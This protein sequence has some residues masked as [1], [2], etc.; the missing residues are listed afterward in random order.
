VLLRARVG[1]CLVRKRARD[2]E[3]E[4]LRQVRLLTAAAESLEA[5]RLDATALAEVTARR[6]ALG[7]LARVLERAA[8]EIHAREQRLALQVQ[9]LRI[10]IDETRKA[11]A[12]AEIVE[13]DYFHELQRRAAELRRQV[14]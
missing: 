9:Q 1:A 2:Q 12:V 4:Y 10:E 6:D 13:S 7:G 3:L 11:R 8:R 14:S 5:G